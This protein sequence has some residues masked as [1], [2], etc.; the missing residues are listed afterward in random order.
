MTGWKTG[1]LSLPFMFLCLFIFVALLAPPFSTAALAGELK[2]K[3]RNV[4][5]MDAESGTVFFKKKADDLI[6]PASMSKIVTLLYV[7][8]LIRRGKLSE[9]DEFE[10]SVNAW[11][12]GGAPSG[13]STMFAKPHERIKV[14]DL[15]RAVAVISANDAAIALAEGIAGTE[16][17]FA[18]RLN[19]FARKKLGLTRSH[20]ANA[21]GLPH[22]KHRMTARELAMAARYLIREFPE[23]YKLYSEREFIWNKIKQ[24]NRNPLLGKYP[25]ADGVKT[26]YT[27]E[28]GYSLVASARRDGRR[29]IAVFTGLR[30]KAERAKEARNILNWGF[31]Q[32][33]PITLFKAGEKVTKVRVWGGEKD[34]VPLVTKKDI[35]V[36]LTNAERRRAGLV[37]KVKAPLVAPVSAGMP[38]GELL[39]YVNKKVVARYPLYTGESVAEDAD[40]WGRAFDTL[41]V[42]LLGG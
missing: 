10:V 15:I 41:K 35:V 8:D 25:G 14:R 7:F 34:K 6:P 26:G 33:R 28:A 29:L 22:P 19:E 23:Y 12:R 38:V 17:A 37:A 2:T 9:D 21:T 32:F 16:E 39:V 27:K 18:E 30:S 36:R 20:F 24:H 1:A 5:V 40:M 11:K 3:A 4:I 13:G 31:A 42:W